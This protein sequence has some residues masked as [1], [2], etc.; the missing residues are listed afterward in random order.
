MACRAELGLCRAAQF[1][2]APDA[3]SIP[4]ARSTLSREY[5]ETAWK[6]RATKC[7]FGR[8]KSA[9]AEAGA[10]ET[11]SGSV[12]LHHLNVIAPLFLLNSIFEAS[13]CL[14]PSWP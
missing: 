5:A 9:P 2:Q 14:A 11:V 8:K 12:A 13:I 7:Y 10:H 3:G 6:R 1:F 4:V